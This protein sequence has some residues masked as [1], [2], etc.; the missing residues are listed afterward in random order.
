FLLL[1]GLLLLIAWRSRSRRSRRRPTRPDPHHHQHRLR[2][3]F[4]ALSLAL[5]LWQL[6][7]FAETR[8]ASQAAQLW[9][10]RLNFTAMVFAPYCALR[11]VRWVAHRSTEP[12]RWLGWCRAE[13]SL[14]ALVTLLAPL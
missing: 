12:A 14:L 11:F 6:T 10:G 13:T 4:F 9:L 1:A 8:T 2:C 7:L 5:L 3:A